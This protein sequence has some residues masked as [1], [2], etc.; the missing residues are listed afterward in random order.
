VTPDIAVGVAGRAKFIDDWATESL[1]N[2][3]T[4]TVVHMGCGMDSRVFRLDPPPTVEWF[5][6][7]YPEVI[8]LRRQIYPE[9][10][11]YHT[12]GSS[13][14]DFAWLD[15]IPGDRPGL[16]IAE[17]L[18]MYLPREEGEE[19]VRR[20]IAKFPSGEMIFDT[21]SRYLVRLQ[22]ERKTN[23]VVRNVNATLDWGIDDVH[24]LERLGLTDVSSVVKWRARPDLVARLS[25]RGKFQLRVDSLIPSRRRK[26][27]GTMIVRGR[28]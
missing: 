4:V 6:V 19:L 15:T 7:D 22:N 3:P 10:A 25:R 18:V 8:A 17:G 5:D 24:E 1:R 28:F 12:I 9:R 20:L 13:V 16:V 23:P 11:H 21:H 27:R 14:T 2:N 26:A